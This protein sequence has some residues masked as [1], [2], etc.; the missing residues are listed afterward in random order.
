MP[1]AAPRPA[2]ARPE[3]GDA[4]APTRAARRLRRLASALHGRGPTQTERSHAAAASQTY[5]SLSAAP[6]LLS[7]PAAVTPAWRAAPW[8][9][10]PDDRACLAARALSQMLCDEPTAARCRAKVRRGPPRPWLGFALQATPRARPS[11]H[12]YI[13]QVP[14][15]PR[16]PRPRRRC[17]AARLLRCGSAP[18]AAACRTH[19]R[20][21]W[22]T[23]AR[24]TGL[25][26]RWRR[27]WATCSCIAATTPWP[28]PRCWFRS[29]HGL[30]RGRAR[31]CT[32]RDRCASRRLRSIRVFA[33]RLLPPRASG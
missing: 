28:R 31:R 19:R 21:H 32:R 18:W 8:G 23:R 25:R 16:L 6:T 33:S 3:R 12:A 1:R 14:S 4:P 7:L 27:P 22:P 2:S 29:I 13:A 15:V 24:A 5:A 30:R 26:M 10:G 17:T 11:L 20:R 9:A